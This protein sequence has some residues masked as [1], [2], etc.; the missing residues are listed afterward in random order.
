[1]KAGFLG[2]SRR[3]ENEAVLLE[4]L[5]KPTVQLLMPSRE[6]AEHYARLYVQLR[7]AGTPVP[8]NDLW[9]AALSLEHDLTLI[10]RDHHFR[11]FPQ[12]L[13]MES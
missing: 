3:H 7:A 1:M 6:T 9:I 10:S 2:G 4:F 13:R 8:I 5:S 11:S 12:L